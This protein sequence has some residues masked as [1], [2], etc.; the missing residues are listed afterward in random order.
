[1]RPIQ[2][3]NKFDLYKTFVTYLW[4]VGGKMLDIFGG[5]AQKD[6]QLTTFHHG[7]IYNKKQ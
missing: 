2:N 6:K 3:S 7:V 1:M 5:S 4:K